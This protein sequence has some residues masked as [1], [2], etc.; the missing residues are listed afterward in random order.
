MTSSGNVYSDTLQSITNAKLEELARKR[1][2]YEDQKNEVLSTTRL[3]S[4]G[5]DGLQALLDVSRPWLV[6]RGAMRMNELTDDGTGRPEMFLCG[7]SCP[8]GEAW[9]R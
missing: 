5:V 2:I 4:N 1:D 7:D 8:E 9:T 3:S 6:L